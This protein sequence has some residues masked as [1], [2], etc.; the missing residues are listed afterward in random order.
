M[1][2]ASKNSQNFVITNH[3]KRNKLSLLNILERCFIIFVVLF[4]AILA[5]ANTSNQ[6]IQSSV[7]EFNGNYG[8]KE[9]EW[10]NWLLISF[11]KGHNIT[12]EW[13]HL[14]I[15]S[16]G[17]LLIF[18]TF[19]KNINMS[20]VGLIAYAIFPFTIDFIQT[21][22]FAA[23]ALIIF[24]LNFLIKRKSFFNRIFFLVFILLGAG[25][26]II[27]YAF[28]PLFFLPSKIN[29]KK[30]F[31]IGI[32]LLVVTLSITLL[33]KF[34]NIIGIVLNNL[35][36]FGDLRA[37][38]YI[39]SST[40]FG[41]VVYWAA[42][43]L[44]FSLMWIVIKRSKYDKINKEY[45]FYLLSFS[46]VC[47]VFLLMPLI[48]RS[49]T[50]FRL[51]RI[52]I[53]IFIFAWCSYSKKIKN[54]TNKFLAYLIPIALSCFLFAAMNGATILNDLSNIFRDNWLI[55]KTRI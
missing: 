47:Y 52:S 21:P 48:S 32:A 51:E 2:I 53:L 42:Q 54:T 17:Y 10:L 22:N 38:K 26:Q 11:C 8:I 20:I 35:P 40:N 37:E 4:I 1:N 36:S 18:Y 44:T 12:F 7:W 39:D 16:L 30:L 27:A 33:D 14:F 29:E 31:K 3:Q 9:G 6:D 50:L 43:L 24:S 45:Q 46:I 19:F 15:Y 28:V 13:Y 23:M 25:M 41:F 55:N 49:G 34:T 5:G